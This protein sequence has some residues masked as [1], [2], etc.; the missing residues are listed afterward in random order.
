MRTL[1]KV[2]LW[3]LIVCLVIPVAA[4]GKKRRTIDVISTDYP[5][6]TCL[7]EGVLS[8]DTVE[9]YREISERY[10]CFLTER[11][12]YLVVE[13]RDAYNYSSAMDTGP[14]GYFIGSNAHFNSWVKWF[15]A[16][17]DDGEKLI[18]N[19][20]CL[21][22]ILIRES[23]GYAITRPQDYED[24]RTFVRHLLFDYDKSEWTWDCVLKTDGYLHSYLY[25]K[26]DGCI[27]MS[28]DDGFYK[29]DLDGYGLTL[30]KPWDNLSNNWK[31]SSIVKT[32]D[33][34]YFGCRLG[35]SEYIPVTDEMY[36]YY[37][38]YE[39]YVP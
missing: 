33:K 19:E 30:I 20:R 26:E 3:I 13:N 23:E 8:F 22:F 39:K 7:E 31:P 36:L 14:H 10:T 32:D 15:P 37:I 27:F 34:F 2:V 1:K 21:G 11:N 5:G 17:G 25:C 18:A 16:N 38:P 9:K 12:G 35:I 29:F 28:L 24:R 6:L 4:C